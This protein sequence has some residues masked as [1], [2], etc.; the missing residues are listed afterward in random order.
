MIIALQA[1]IFFRESLL[2]A[3]NRLLRPYYKHFLSL[4]RDENT[5]DNEDFEDH[6]FA[7]FDDEKGVVFYPPVYA[8]RYAA[9][10][11]CLMDERWCGKLEKVVD[12]GYHDIS[13]IKY[14]KEVP[15]IKCI[16]GVDIESIPLRCSSDIFAIDE[17]SLKREKPLQ[18]ILFQGNAADPDYRLIGCD[19]VVAIEMIE[20]MLPHDLERLV[21]TVFGFIKPW[22]AV[23]TTPNSDFNVLFKALEKNGLR[24]LDHFFEWSREQFHDWCSNIVSRYPQYTVSCK[25]VGPG[26]PGTLHYGC[27]S[28][29]AVFI[30]KEYHKQQD[31][32]LNSLAL[33]ANAPK[34]N[35]ASDMIGTW[36]YPGSPES[37]TK[38]K[39]LCLPN[40]LNCT[41]LQVKKFSKTTQNMMLKN[42]FDSIVHTRQ[43]VDEIQH[44]TK[45][46][47]FDK[48]SINKEHNGTWCNINWGDNAPYWNQYYKVV[49]EYNYPFENKS[50]ECRILDLISEEMNRLIDIQYDEECSLDVNKFE[51]PIDQLMRV[52]EHITDDVDRVK[53]LLEWNGYEVVG[54]TVIHSRIVVDSGSVPTHD[55][56]WQDNDTFSDVKI[57]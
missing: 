7:E 57:L 1:L 19:A 41:T 23:F 5:S 50:E 12:L 15:G 28:Q 14:L 51:I 4:N 36:E 42:R 13:F 31:L 47:N 53:D 46:L 26:P 20:H 32:N 18:V 49:R 52:V 35:D 34:Y 16:L 40:R 11:D 33:V 17:Y 25:G 8:Q 55:D 45:M 9:V 48:E 21:H 43:V 39:M 44:L 54:D 27:C 6:V 38:N 22:I 29:L 10:S 2:T 37:Q 56:D 3:I 30:S 24:R